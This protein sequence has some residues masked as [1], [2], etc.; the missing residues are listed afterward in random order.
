MKW[1]N[2]SRSVVVSA[3]SIAWLLVAV[4]GA[5][6]VSSKGYQT[7]MGEKD[8]EIRQLRE[9]RAALKAQIQKQQ[10]D[11]DS[12]RGQ[13]AEASGK[14]G[15]GQATEPVAPAAEKYPELD[16]VGVSY[17]R[18][19]GNLV[20]SIPS[21]ITFPSGQ[22]TLSSEGHKALKEVASVLKKQHAGAKYEI[23]GHTDTD[24]IKKS[25]FTSNRELSIARAMAV[26]TYFVEDCGIKDDQCIVAG[27]GQ[28][29]PVAKNDND[30]DK[31]RNRRV[32]IVVHRK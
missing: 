22:A 30:K 13:A 8:A 21:S 5:G 24:P 15:E 19:D 7:A 6:C 16:Q 12:A 25:K 17:G 31:A 28:Y 4:V 26:L 23:E 9:E 32:E 27:F 20:I 29:E 2:R 10:G 14:V 18:R 1:N 3:T 11:L